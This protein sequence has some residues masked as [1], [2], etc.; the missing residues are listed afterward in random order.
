MDRIIDR[1]DKALKDVTVPEAMRGQQGPETSGV[2]IQSKQFAKASSSWLCR[3]TTWPTRA[4]CWPLGFLKLIQ[5]YYDTH[6]IFRITETDPMT[7]GADRAGAGDQ[8]F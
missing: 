3:W 6:R 8:P 1:A 7:G 4:S 2:A 5:R